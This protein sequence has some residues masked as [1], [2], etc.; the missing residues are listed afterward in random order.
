MNEEEF[1]LSSAKSQREIDGGLDL[2]GVQ[3][4]I[5]FVKAKLK[6]EEM[7]DGEILEIIIDDGEPVRNVP[8]SLKEEGHGILKAE[9]CGDGGFR[10][11]I[12]KGGGVRHGG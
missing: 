2:R 12:R 3:C 1:C 9:R 8:R 6:L 5:N 11:L 10:L 7:Q 4:P